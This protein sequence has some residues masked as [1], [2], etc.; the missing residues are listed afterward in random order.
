MKLKKMV[1]IDYYPTS[2]EDGVHWSCAKTT[3]I[4]PNTIVRIDEGEIHTIT[5]KEGYKNYTAL[6]DV[7]MYPF[8][9][10]IAVGQGINGVDY[11]VFWVNEKTYKKV[12]ENF[13]IV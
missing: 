8:Y 2:W 3:I 9:T 7:K 5:K 4:D 12:L 11:E 13:E 1:E 6:K 10:S